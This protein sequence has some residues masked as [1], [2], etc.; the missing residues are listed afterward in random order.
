MNSRSAAILLT[1]T[2]LLAVAMLSAGCGGSQVS[3]AA[4]G[5]HH[6]PAVVV[7]VRDVSRYGKV[8]M[9]SSGYAL[10]IFQPD[11]QKHV[12]CTGLC[13]A[14]WPPL[15]VKPGASIVAGPGVRQSLLGS[16]PDPAGGRVVTYGG[17]PL[18]AYD[19]DVSMGQV[20]GQGVDL[21]GGEWFLMRPS[22]KPLIFN[23][24][25]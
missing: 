22:G 2:M 23:P 3:S 19:G 10:Y 4:G 21:N 15:K 18:Y 9:D 12:T 8:L 14:T 16:D 20:T 11:D 24:I 6:G 25:A 5:G 7:R 17:W 13:A 1:G